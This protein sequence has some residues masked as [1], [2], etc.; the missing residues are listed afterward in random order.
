MNNFFKAAAVFLI[1]VAMAHAGEE[2][3]RQQVE[4]EITPLNQ[5]AGI[6]QIYFCKTVD[7]EEVCVE[8]NK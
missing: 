3:Q 5:P 8:S 6:M 1:L 4:Q 7:N 2:E